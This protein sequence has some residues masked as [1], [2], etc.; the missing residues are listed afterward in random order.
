MSSIPCALTLN[1]VYFGGT[2]AFEQFAEVTLSDKIFAQFFP[3]GGLPLGCF[4]TETLRETPPVGFAVYLVK[5]GLALYAYDFPPVDL[6]LCPVDQK[7]EGELLATLFYQGKPQLC[8]ESPQGYFN[9]TLPPS[10]APQRLLFYRNFLFVEGENALAVY[11]FRCNLLFCERIAEY[12]TTEKGFNAT[13][14]L[15]DRLGRQA[16]CE[17]ELKEGCRLLRRT[18]RQTTEGGA[19]PADLLAYAFFECVRLGGD[20]VPFL[21]DTLLS[22]KENILSF[23]GEFCEVVLTDDPLTCGL[24]KKKKENLF[25]VVYHAVV[26]ENAK[27]VDIRG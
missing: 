14:P 4:L 8:V 23:L 9:A 17:Y 12:S 19:L 20:I 7:R 13:L 22:E 24:V 10:F 16:I 3:A 15:S 18:L 5:D 1:G 27:I 2:G 26:V 21:G 11:D 6:T 25:E